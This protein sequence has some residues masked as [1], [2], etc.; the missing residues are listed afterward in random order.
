MECPNCH[1]EN[2]PTAI[3]CDCGYNFQDH[4]IQ[5]NKATTSAGITTYDKVGGWLLFLCVILTI[6]S[7][8]ITLIMFL[9]SPDG[10]LNAL[11]MALA[12]LITF[13]PMAYS[14]FTGVR[15]W[16]VKP[17]AVK[18]AKIFLVVIALYNILL[19]VVSSGA[20][21]PTS[22]DISTTIRSAI[23][24]FIWFM[25]LRSSKRVTGTFTRVIKVQSQNRDTDSTIA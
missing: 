24:S 8:I 18:Q 17:G 25:Y 2:P 10:E 22:S 16:M 23:S 5:T 21:S 7:P 15:L 14:I 13:A 4:L 20:S 9:A 19:L 11:G 12:A 6:L 3:N 1:L